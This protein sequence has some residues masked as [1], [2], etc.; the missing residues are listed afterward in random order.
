M[1]LVFI[2]R[3]KQEANTPCWLAVKHAPW[4][5]RDVKGR[6]QHWDAGWADTFLWSSGNVWF[7]SLP[8]PFPSPSA[9]SWEKRHFLSFPEHPA[10]SPRTYWCARDAAHPRQ[11]QLIKVHQ[12]GLLRGYL[13]VVFF[14]FSFALGL[15]TSSA[16]GI[17]IM[18]FA[19]SI[20]PTRESISLIVKHDHLFG[21]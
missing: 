4:S 14:S 18:F 10:T 11:F 6:S 17:F 2:L 9:A 12:A 16:D 19:K 1:I 7:P 3:S 20:W 15:S 8:T 13:G 21:F 5:P